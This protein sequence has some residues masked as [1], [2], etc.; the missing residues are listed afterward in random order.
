MKKYLFV[1]IAALFSLSAIA[2]KNSKTSTV[3]VDGIKFFNG[4][5]EKALEEA[6]KQKK[7]IFMDAYTTWCGPCKM[8]SAKTFPDK[9]VGEFFNKHFINVKMDMEKGE[10]PNLAM[11]YDVKAYPTLLFIDKSGKKLHVKLGFVTPE[12]LI[13]EGKKVIDLIK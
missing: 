10:G 7:I 13:E 2:Q 3:E 6:A 1:F 12:V 4:T 9:A 5:F 8:L 11:K